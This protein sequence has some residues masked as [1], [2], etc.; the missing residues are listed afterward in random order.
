VL[1]IISLR[2]CFL[3]S[4]GDLMAYRPAILAANFL[5]DV[6]FFRTQRQYTSRLPHLKLQEIYINNL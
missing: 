2:F 5:G 6:S 3:T 1:K 4:L